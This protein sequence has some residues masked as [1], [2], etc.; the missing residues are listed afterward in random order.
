MASA[1]TAIPSFLLPRG[2]SQRTIHLLSRRT[3][4]SS[5]SRQYHATLPLSSKPPKP[6]KGG[7]G[8]RVLEKPDKFRP[9]S[10]PAHRVMTNNNA[11]NSKVAA[12]PRNYPGPALTAKEIEERKTKKYPNM[13]PPEGTVMY[14]F[15]TNRGIHVWISLSVLVTL[16]TFTFTT[17][18][19]RTSP[20]TH[21]LPSWSQLL[22]NP[23]V[24]VSQ[25]MSVVKMHSDH[26]TLQ[27][28]ERRKQNMGDVE[29]R[30]AYRRAH[31]LEKEEEAAEGE[32][33]QVGGDGVVAVAGGE[34]AA[35]AEYADWEGRRKPIKKWFGIW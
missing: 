14:K 15:L 2:I 22:T 20:F 25:V 34:G 21:L 3:P 13:F 26:V 27:T 11:R 19:K 4:S 32:G 1:A 33:Q 12:E 7:G 31:G 16:A 35:A 17:N 8:A 23:I 9:P 29:K 24:T 30:K 5:S 28:A 10:H 18:F 6:S